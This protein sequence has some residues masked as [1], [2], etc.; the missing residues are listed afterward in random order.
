[1]P[2][3]FRLKRFTN[4]AIL[5]RIDFPLL[6]AFFESDPEFERFLEKR[7]L[8]WTRAVEAFDYEGL[9]RI[10]MSP[11][12]DT[13]DE[14]L[15]ALYFVDNLADPDCYDR[16]LEECGAAGIDLGKTD[17]SPEDLTLRV[18]LA[19]RN[20]LERIHAEQYR[21]RPKKFESF[22]AAG[23]KRPPLGEPPAAVLTALETD[24]NEWYEFKKKG[25]G[26]RVFPFARDDTVW[27]LV[28][29]GQRI[30]REGTVEADGE[31]GRIFYRPEMFDVLIYYPASGELAIHTETKGEQKAYC[32][33]FGKHLFDDIEFFLFENPVAKY[34]L[35]PLINLGR[36]ALVC[37]DI[38][39]IECIQL[40]ELH[41]AHDSD[42]EDVEVRR[43]SEDVFRTL[44][45]QGRNLKDEESSIQLVKAKFMV[46][47]AG[48]KERTVIIEP[49]KTASF[50]READNAVIH[51][52]LQKRGFISLVVAEVS[53]NDKADV[54]LATR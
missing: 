8:T 28:R 38:E 43:A 12:V 14:L 22:F 11:G 15:D 45:N 5:K 36:D 23:A 33:Y 26:A 29:H 21:V 54:V 46:R 37:D 10:L 42:Q 17:P 39:G 16:I 20:I 50:D 27:F 4:V 18:W 13:P 9:A 34:T 52:W 41:I 2:E 35:Q 53:S 32:R 30:K 31:S 7:G 1:M 47:F 25:R 40:H 19:D 24:L 48:G 44:E 51:E 6:L 49:P 3:S